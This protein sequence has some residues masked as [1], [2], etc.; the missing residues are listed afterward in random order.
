MELTDL[1]VKELAKGYRAKEFSASDVVKAYLAKIEKEN[2]K[3]NAYLEVF[4]DVLEQA[5]IVDKRLSQEEGEAHPLMGVPIALKDN[6]LIKGK[7][8]SAA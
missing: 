8:A 3:L 7:R 1:S 6:I 2:P 4:S 5:K